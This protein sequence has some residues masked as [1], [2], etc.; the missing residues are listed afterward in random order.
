[1]RTPKSEANKTKAPTVVVSSDL[2]GVRCRCKDPACKQA[3]WFDSA[4]RALWHTSKEGE[5]SL[6]Y[7][8]ANACVELIKELR[9]VLTQMTDTKHA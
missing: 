6:M 7:L 1:M 2:L 5:E 3:I 8:D 4:S 9:D